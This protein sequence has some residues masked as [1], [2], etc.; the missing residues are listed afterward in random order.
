MSRFHPCDEHGTPD[1]DWPAWINVPELSPFPH[2]TRY[3]NALDV[4]RK[5]MEIVLDLKRAGYD[6]A[7]YEWD[8][9]ETP[10]IVPLYKL[11]DP[12]QS[13]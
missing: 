8:A 2:E 12:Q 5:K 7:L 6:H 1:P 10:R 13:D 4:V 3:Y 11:H 9:K